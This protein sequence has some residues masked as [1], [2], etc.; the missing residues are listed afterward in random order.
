MM[1]LKQF[2]VEHMWWI[3]SKSKFMKL[4]FTCGFKGWYIINTSADV[5]NI[6]K[7][8]ND[9]IITQVKSY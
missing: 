3:Q 7:F 9:Q 1:I 5:K 4:C 8:G 6:T 2:E